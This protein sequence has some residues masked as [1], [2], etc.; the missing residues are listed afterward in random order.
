VAITSLSCLDREGNQ[1]PWFT[2]IKYPGNVSNETARYAYFDPNLGST[3]YKI[4]LGSH[5]D[6]KGEALPNTIEAINEISSEHLNLLVYNDEPPNR[7]WDPYGGHAKGILAFDNQTNTGVYIMH[8]FPKFPSVNE[9]TGY[10]K[11]STPYNTYM[12]GQNAYCISL[13]E[14]S[15]PFISA[16]LP[17]EWPNIYYSSGIFN[18]S[19][20]DSP[21]G[22]AVSHF[23]L[24]NGEDQWLLTKNPNNT[25]FLFEDIISPYFDVCLAVESWGRPYQNPVCPED[26]GHAILNID[27]IAFNSQDTWDHYSDHSKWA[28]SIGTKENENVACL[29]DMNRMDSQ[30]VRGGSCLCSKNPLLYGALNSI[31]IATDNCQTERITY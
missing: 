9:S 5:C 3:T 28:I 31:I 18:K 24:L 8:S 17:V 27:H 16:H 12:Y 26:G 11:Y 14:T 4:I 15:L 2:F 10:I 21:I 20:Y 29:C 22:S 23:T 6:T 19:T 13:N 25:G 7:E 30:E 1:V